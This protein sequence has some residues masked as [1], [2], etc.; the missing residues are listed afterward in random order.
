MPDVKA[1]ALLAKS[2]S[3]EKKELAVEDFVDS[4]NMYNNSNNLLTITSNRG[5]SKSMIIPTP[6][7]DFTDRDDLSD[8]VCERDLKRN[9]AEES[10]KG[11]INWINCY[12]DL[13]LLRDPLFILMCMSVTLMSTGCPYMLYYL[14]AYV[15]SAG[16]TK[17]EAGYMVAISA[18]LDLIGRLGFGYLSDLQLF[19]RRKAY[20]IW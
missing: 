1:T 6:I 5:L 12:L 13:S 7:S 14:P 10:P 8:S 11:C 9:R 4:N 19:D 2:S 18:A 17:S 15:L 3:V 16:Y 20:I